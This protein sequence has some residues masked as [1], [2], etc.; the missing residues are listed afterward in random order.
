MIHYA[1]AREAVE[2]RTFLRDLGVSQ[3]AILLYDRECHQPGLN[4]LQRRSALGAGK[5]GRTWEELTAH[6]AVAEPVRTILMLA[7]VQERLLKY[8]IPNAN[9][10]MNY[11]TRLALMLL[12]IT[13]NIPVGPVSAARRTRLN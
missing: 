6:E 13:D 3:N 7:H 8:V 4:K 1:S 11:A 10:A 2:F 9:R 5:L 12:A